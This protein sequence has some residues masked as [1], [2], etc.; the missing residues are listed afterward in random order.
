MK[1]GIVGSGFV[2]STAAYALVMRGIGREIVLVDQDEKRA[3]AEADDIFHAVPFANS[4]NVRAGTYADLKGASV[5]IM[6]AGVNQ[7][8]G[9]TRMQLLERN[10]HVFYSVIP[11]I[12][13]NAP[14]A[15]IVVATNP[16]DVMTHLT[17]RIAAE[18]GIP[19]G[20]V[21]GSGTTL[22]T[23]R[24]RVLLSRHLKIDPQHV[25]AYVVGEHGDTEVLLWS[26]VGVGGVPVNDYLA[27]RDLEITPEDKAMIDEQVRR[28][29]Y[30]IIEG[31]KATYY[32]VGAAL[33]RI[34][35]VILNNQQ[36]ILTICAPH[37]EIVS[38]EDVTI[39]L[40]HVISGEGIIGSLPLTISDDEKALLAHSARTVRAAIDL[41]PKTANP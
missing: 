13:S 24:F 9:E 29:A 26:L 20:S 10:A 14:N 11:N 30:H 27:A 31:K 36:A 3:K 39:A 21:L 5:V 37:Q 12:I 33:A 40:P 2:G 34:C 23:A 17:A 15:I 25:H 4:L 6:A 41:L 7:K 8:P 32:G 35:E 18:R 38:V 28:A 22:D 19:A 1:I 16:V